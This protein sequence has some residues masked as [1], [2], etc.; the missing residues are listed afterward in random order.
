MKRLD[1][2]TEEE[3]KRARRWGVLTALLAGVFLGIPNVAL[4]ETDALGL[5]LG[6]ISMFAGLRSIMGIFY[7]TA[8]LPGSV[9]SRV[10]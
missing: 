9:L 1:Q 10:W 4:F 7:L 6:S 2:M 5:N 8:F 3:I